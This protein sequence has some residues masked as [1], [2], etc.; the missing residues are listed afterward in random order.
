MIDLLERSKHWE[1]AIPICKVSFNMTK[2][3]V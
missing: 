1:H 3:L 2:T